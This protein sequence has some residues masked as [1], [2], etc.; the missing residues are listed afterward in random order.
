MIRAPALCVYCPFRGQFYFRLSNRFY[1]ARRDTRQAAVAALL[2]FR[3]FVDALVAIYR[4]RVLVGMYVL[5]MYVFPTP[6][7]EVGL[8]GCS[9]L[10]EGGTRQQ[11]S[12]EARWTRAPAGL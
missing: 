12:L 10:L 8:V 5:G 4:K 2:L 11:A 3:T 1:R 6:P 7:L 9:S